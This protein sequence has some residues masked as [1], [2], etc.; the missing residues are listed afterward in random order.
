MKQDEQAVVVFGA[1][2]GI[3]EALARRLCKEGHQ[4][5]ITGRNEAAAKALSAELHMPY[6]IVEATSFEDVEAAL[7]A[8]NHH[9]GRITGVVNCCG[10]L[11]LKPAH[12]TSFEEWSDTIA[13][14]LTT[15]FAV[16]RAGGLHLSDANMVLVST[17]ATRI[18]LPNHEAIAAAKGGIEAL[19]RTAAATYSKKKIRINCVAPGLT[20]TPLT[21]QLTENPQSLKA[22]LSMHALGE[23]GEPED[24]A[25]AIHWFLHPAQ[26]W[27]TGQVLGVDGGLGSLRVPW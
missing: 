18:G 24:V 15:S 4:V 17:A 13:N 1:T 22:S 2:S 21:K 7:S 26:T 19:T 25:S 6:Q 9:F 5:F 10:S 11:F 8:A 23:I 12:R 3:G 20:R 27:V 14:N 16:V